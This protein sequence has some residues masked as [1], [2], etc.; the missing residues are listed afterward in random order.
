M[1][2]TRTGER[3]PRGTLSTHTRGLPADTNHNGDIFGG[4]LLGEM[5]I[6]GRIFAH[7]VREGGTSTI[8]VDA[9][10]FK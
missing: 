7:T 1:P 8:A 10:T 4:W 5:D 6:A 2:A 9:M 3:E